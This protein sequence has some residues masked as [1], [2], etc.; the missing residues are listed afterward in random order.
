MHNN[1]SSTNA[2]FVIEGTVACPDGE[3]AERREVSIGKRGSERLPHDK[4]P[5]ARNNG[6][7]VRLIIGKDTYETILH[8][9]ESS[10]YIADAQRIMGFHLKDLLQCYGLNKRR[11]K[12][13]LEFKGVDIRISSL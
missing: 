7:K 4:F 9:F 8:R 10:S 1:A 3:Q 13:R 2:G 12:L 5:I 11:K 6:T